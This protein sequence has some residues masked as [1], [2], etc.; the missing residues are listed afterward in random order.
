VGLPF[1]FVFFYL[2]NTGAIAWAESVII[3]VMILY[4]FGTAFA[5]ISLLAGSAAAVGLFLL[6]GNS[7]NGIPWEPL[8]LQVPIIAFVVA[9]VIVI[10]LDRQVLLEQKQRGVASAL[11][12]V[13][14]ELRTPLASLAITT[15]GLKARISKLAYEERIHVEPLIQAAERMHADLAHVNCS[16][17]LLLANSRDPYA[18]KK[19]PFDPAEAIRAAVERFPFTDEPGPDIVSI[20]SSSGAK[21]LGNAQLFELVVTNLTKNALE[22]IKRAGKGDI[23]IRCDVDDRGVCVVFRDTATGVSPQILERMFQPFFSY[24]AHRGTGIGLAFCRKVLNSWGATISCNS[25]EHEFTEFHIR[26]PRLT[27]H[28]S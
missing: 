11:A 13:A 9:V 24:P 5:T 22:A 6:G 18:A 28:D 8:L 16:L 25:V 3:A 19:E 1:A 21:V 2:E 27:G 10:K 12:T 23:Q 20:E 4:H 7:M 26:L 15:D 17:E 14:H